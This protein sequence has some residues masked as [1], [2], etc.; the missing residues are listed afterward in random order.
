MSSER[1]I[2]NSIL[3]VDDD[4]IIRDLL[5]TLFT[6]SGYTVDLA[7][8]GREGFE[9]IR[10]K[11]YNAIISDVNMPEMNGM[12]LYYAARRYSPELVKRFLFITSGQEDATMAFFGDNRCRYMIKPFNFADMLDN[13]KTMAIGR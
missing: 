7:G 12:A 10:K 9:K 5:Y 3:V 6:E 13:V 1:E 2:K 11:S 8:N 4:S